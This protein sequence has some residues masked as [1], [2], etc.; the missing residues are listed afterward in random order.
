MVLGPPQPRHEDSRTATNQAHHSR[1][2]LSIDFRMPQDN[3]VDLMKPMDTGDMENFE[4]EDEQKK[5]LV[6]T[7]VGKSF[8][9]FKY[10]ISKPSLVDKFWCL[11]NKESLLKMRKDGKLVQ[12]RRGLGSARLHL[13]KAAEERGERTD[14]LAQITGN[15]SVYFKVPKNERAMPT[16]VIK[17]K[18]STLT[19]SGHIEWATTFMPRTAA[20]LRKQMQTHLRSMI[21]SPD[22][23]TL[24]TSNEQGLLSTE[25]E[26]V[27][28]EP[29]APARR[30][31]PVADA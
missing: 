24:T 10:L 4:W 27:R 7:K 8:N 18:V 26:S 6:P 14:L 9:E 19:K 12:R 29:P 30:R 11:E 1:K 23:P 3:F 31:T 13:S 25:S 2:E 17:C 21:E 5:S 16:G 28:Q 20:A 15:V 22:Y